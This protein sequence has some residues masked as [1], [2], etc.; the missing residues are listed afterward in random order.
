[1]F[2]AIV[3]SVGLAMSPPEGA[4][5]FGYRAQI[6]SVDLMNSEGET[7]Q[8]LGAILQQ[9]RANFH[10]FGIRQDGDEHDPFFDDFQTRAQMQALYTPG[11]RDAEIEELLAFGAGIQL[12]VEV[13]L[14]NGQPVRISV[15]YDDAADGSCD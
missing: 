4:T 10:R 15:K 11:P 5:T 8:N 3:M 2:S 9:D 7:L 1:M 14:R 13:C 6:E 12:E